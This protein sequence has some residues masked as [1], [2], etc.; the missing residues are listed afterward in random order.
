MFQGSAYSKTSALSGPPWPR[1]YRLRRLTQRSQV[2][3][4]GPPVERHRDLYTP[5]YACR[6]QWALI[7][8][9]KH[10]HAD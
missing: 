8:C 6:L 10:V 7:R 9:G 5:I 1:G 4:L 2:Q 3:I